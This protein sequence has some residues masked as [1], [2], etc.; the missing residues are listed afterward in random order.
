M[1]DVRCK[2]CS[3]LLFKIEDDFKSFQAIELKCPKCGYID[4]FL[5]FKE[6]ITGIK[7]G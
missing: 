4:N 5:A 3:R 7:I 6:P 1:K 2:R